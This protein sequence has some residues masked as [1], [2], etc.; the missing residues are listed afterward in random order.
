MATIEQSQQADSE[1][2]ASTSKVLLIDLENCPS[3]VNQL[4][5]NLEQ[6]SRVVVCYAVSGA[7]IPLDW[8]VPLTATVNDN[9]LKIVKMPNGGKNAADFGIT[10]WAGVL[11]AQMSEH[12]HFDIVS[13]DGD[14]DHAVNLL[15][16]QKRSAARI[17]KKENLIPNA[18]ENERVLLQKQ[19]QVY[20]LHLKNHNKPA[21]RET[22]INSIK[23]AFKADD[24]NPESLLSELVKQGVVEVGD[25]KTSKTTYAPAK[26]AK[27]AGL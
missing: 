7:K 6:Y 16:S 24:I 2:A 25:S 17:G 9:R 22:L 3:Q 5:D 19:L 12:T 18:L 1:S 11:M 23:S 21:K 20:C 8:I 27:L 13:N 4:F 14:L 10:F 15:R 26:I